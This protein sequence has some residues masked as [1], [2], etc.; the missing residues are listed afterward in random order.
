ME[1]TITDKL[2]FETVHALKFFLKRTKQHATKAKLLYA[3]DLAQ[4]LEEHK[5]KTVSFSRV[6]IKELCLNGASDW[7]RYSEGGCSLI[8]NGDIIE[9]CVC[10]SLHRHAEN[11]DLIKIQSYFLAEGFKK[12]YD[13]LKF[14]IELNS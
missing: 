5:G 13:E 14:Q 11:K 9:R 1:I 7:L 2:L 6:R 8:Y 12:L 4:E 10:P 3:L